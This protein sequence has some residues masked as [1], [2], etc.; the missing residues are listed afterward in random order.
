MH[1]V[2]WIIVFWA[3]V[4]SV[5][6]LFTASDYPFGITQTTLKLEVNSGAPG[7][8]PIPAPLVISFVLFETRTKT[9]VKIKNDSLTIY[10]LFIIKLEKMILHQFDRAYA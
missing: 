5:L 1:S 3:I 4:W 6:R 7:G 10:Q 8:I 9:T 2:L